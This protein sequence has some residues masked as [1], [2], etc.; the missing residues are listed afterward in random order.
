MEP[1][2]APEVHIFLAQ[3]PKRNPT[4]EAVPMRRTPRNSSGNLEWWLLK[5][6]AYYAFVSKIPPCPGDS[7][8]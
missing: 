1:P 8:T 7:K 3:L 2:G 5:P 4:H 6:F